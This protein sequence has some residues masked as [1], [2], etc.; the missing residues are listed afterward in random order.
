VLSDLFDKRVLLLAGKGGVGRTTLAA[1]FAVRG[2]ASGKRVLLV[3]AAAHAG[4][5]AFSPVA[6]LFGRDAFGAEPERLPAPGELYGVRLAPRVGQ[7][8]FLR[9]LLPFGPLV[10]AALG[11]QALA[12]L[13][14]VAPGFDEL[15]IFHHFHTLLEA[16]PRYDLLV[17][18]TPATGHALALA[19]LPDLVLRVLPRGPIADL[20]REGQAL[21]HDPRRAGVVIVTLAEALPVTEASELAQG[22]RGHR[23][24]VAAVIA[25]KARPAVTA[26]ER[27]AAEPLLA[28]GPWLGARR[29]LAAA[30]APEALARLEASS[31]LRP[32]PLSELPLEG[33][34]LI[35]AVAAELAP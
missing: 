24:P 32:H 25:N 18:D 11:S 35:D 10:R 29:F 19:E 20:L 27:A 28:A 2:A 16:Q 7:E 34:A 13:L 26:S 1:A 31:G 21:F 9:R 5:A 8:R 23:L 15:G 17:V 14:D 33:R 30:Q 12:R 6:G 22:L 4:D 3:D